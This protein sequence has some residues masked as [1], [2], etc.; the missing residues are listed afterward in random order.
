MNLLSRLFAHGTAEAKQA[1]EALVPATRG[2]AVCGAPRTGSNY[3]CELLSST[4]VLGRPREYFNGAAR[5]VHDDPD[6]PDD[7]H[8][9]VARILT[10]GATP[11]GIY[12]LKLFPGLFDAVSPHLRLT[13]VL[14]SLSFVRLRRRDSLGQAISWVRS[15]QSRQ[16]RSTE[17]ATGELRY[18]GEAIETYLG[19]A[20]Q[21]N[22]R[23]DMYFARTGIV[24]VEVVYEEMAVDAQAAVDRVSAALGLAEPA[25]IAAERVALR[26]QRDDV[27]AEWRARFVAERGDPN[28][29]DSGE[30][31]ARSL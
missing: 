17:T 16:F 31:L 11:N 22:A 21:R 20:C 29:M 26:V 28:R 27:S 9:Q 7:P 4:G 18:D 23:W 24:P 3:F 10:M 5:R 15:M 13:E 12:G 6:Y 14:P 19:Q 2:Y 30:L 8:A 1:D 25:R